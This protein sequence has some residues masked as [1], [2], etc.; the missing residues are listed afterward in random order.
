MSEC[1]ENM[2]VF[3]GRNFAAVHAGVV[4]LFN[5]TACHEFGISD[6]SGELTAV[7]QQDNYGN[8]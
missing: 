6:I 5:D 4:V 8:I 7:Q 1:L 3:K 2:K